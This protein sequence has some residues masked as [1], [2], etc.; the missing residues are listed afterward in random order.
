SGVFNLPFNPSGLKPS[1]NSLIIRATSNL[2]AVTQLQVQKI[3]VAP[4]SVTISAPSANQIVNGAVRITGSVDS[5]LALSAIQLALDNSAQP[6]IANTQTSPNFDFTIP[7]STLSAGSHSATVTA[8]TNFAGATAFSGS[9]TRNFIYAVPPKLILTSPIDGADLTDFVLVTGSFD[10]GNQSL[11]ALD[12][13]INGA[14]S[15]SIAQYSTANQYSY[16]LSPNQLKD[17]LNSITLS[18]TDSQ[19]LSSAVKTEFNYKKPS[20]ATLLIAPANNGTA[21]GD[22]VVTGKVYSAAALT[23][24]TLTT[25]NQT[26][27]NILSSINN[28]GDFS[29]VMKSSEVLG[30]TDSSPQGNSIRL[31]LDAVSSESKSQATSTFTYYQNTAFIPGGDLVVI[32]DLDPLAA[33]FAS[34]NNQRFALNL[35]D[36]SAPGKLRDNGKVIVFDAEYGAS[37]DSYGKLNKFY[38]DNNW[39]VTIFQTETSS[40]PVTQA[41]YKNIP[42]E[43]KVIFLWAPRAVFSAEKVAALKKFAA[44]GGRIVFM[45]E[46]PLAYSAIETVENDLFAKLGL[47]LQAG[48]EYSNAFGTS[49]A[50]AITA[51]NHP[52][53]AGV[54]QIQMNV[55]LIL[56]PGPNDYPLLTDN[57]GQVVMV[58]TR[59]DGI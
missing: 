26:S 37:S 49:P 1:D 42:A 45:G 53:M 23:R 48:K 56:I 21:S 35:I 51:P 55:P 12:L 29:V 43:V 36:Y 33:Y 25:S 39:R 24:A 14:A 31:S 2:G 22:I 30:G 41:F 52:L 4:P 44:E 34:A 58:S 46:G 16:Y 9:Q 19:G 32:N 3:A 57:E 18:I 40:T 28:A 27:K 47:K 11:K 54:K 20:V 13:W 50:L 7:I 15:T 10:L 8:I 17:G 5:I 38:T 6:N 59:L